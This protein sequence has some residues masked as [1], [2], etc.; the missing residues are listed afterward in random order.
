MNEGNSTQDWKTQLRYALMEYFNDAE[1]RG[2]CFDIGLEY[3]NISAEGKINTVIEMIDYGLRTGTIAN[4]VELCE[5]QRPNVPWQTISLGARQATQQVRIP[6]RRPLREGAGQSQIHQAQTANPT[7]FNPPPNNSRGGINI[8]IPWMIGGIGLFA[9]ICAGSLIFFNFLPPFSNGVDP[10]TPREEDSRSNELAA[11]T[12]TAPTATHTLVIPTVT[13]TSTPESPTSTHTPTPTPTSTNTPIVRQGSP[14]QAP[15]NA[16]EASGWFPTL[17]NLTGGAIREVKNADLYSGSTLQFMNNI[18][19]ITSYE[20]TYK[21]SN[22]CH[23]NNGFEATY[24]QMFYFNDR[25]GAQ[26]FISWATDSWT[27]PGVIRRNDVG[28]L[29]YYFKRQNT[30][31]DGSECELEADSYTFQ[32]ANIVYRV[33]VYT[34]DGDSRWSDSASLNQAIDIAN[35]AA[36]GVPNN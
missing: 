6:R 33:V 25:T 9:L 17:N 36:S 7:I 13:S 34:K 31:L 4:L 11:D 22:L 27:Y 8:A 18:G 16:Q 28:E 14:V 30:N 15:L 26:Q 12:P 5:Q 10:L 1:L 23:S 21:H 19:R 29:S 24:I 2:L 3:E 35:W 32:K 20:R